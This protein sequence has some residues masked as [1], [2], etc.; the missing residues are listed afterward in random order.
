M[1]KWRVWN[2]IKKIKKSIIVYCKWNFV[3]TMK[4]C[5]KFV[6][7]LL[8]ETYSKWYSIFQFFLDNSGWCLWSKVLWLTDI[9]LQ[10]T[11]VYIRYG[12]LK[13]FLCHV[14]IFIWSV[15]PETSVFKQAPEVPM[16]HRKFTEM[17]Y[18]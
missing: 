6:Q 16:S 10:R 4:K 18:K 3:T 9:S 14:G 1:N 11:A 15:F 17:Q 5:A 12:S 13:K 7:F 2:V 8:D